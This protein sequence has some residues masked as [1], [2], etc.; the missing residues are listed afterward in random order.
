MHYKNGRE[1]K[2]NDHVIVPAWDATKQA[3]IA[4]RLHSLNSSSV[5]CNGIVTYATVGGMASTS[6]TV[7]HCIHADDAMTLA[8]NVIN[9]AQ[10]AA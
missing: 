9:S 6:V 1:A 8:T 5:S 3:T 7:G 10:P 4:G 2:E